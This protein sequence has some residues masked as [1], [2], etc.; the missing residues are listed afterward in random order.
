MMDRFGGRWT[1]LGSRPCVASRR[2]V[3]VCGM[4][5]C[6]HVIIFGVFQS[7]PAAMVMPP[8]PVVLMPTVYQQGVGYVP[9]TGACCP[10]SA[11]AGGLRGMTA[12]ME[13]CGVWSAVQ[14]LSLVFI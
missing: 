4:F 11:W 6:D 5:L 1:L 12:G 13:A 10:S 8:Q 3:L 9:I 7:L 2:M 14:W